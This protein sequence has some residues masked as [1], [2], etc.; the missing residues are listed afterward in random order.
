M[1][2]QSERGHIVHRFPQSG[3]ISDFCK[4]LQGLGWDGIYLSAAGGGGG[5]GTGY[6]APWAQQMFDA[7]ATLRPE[8]RLAAANIHFFL[9]DTHSTE[10]KVMLKP[11]A[12]STDQST[13]GRQHI[14]WPTRCLQDIKMS[15]STAD[16][17]TAKR[18]R[19][20]ERQ[21]RGRPPLPPP[22]PMMP[23]AEAVAAAVAKPSG[24]GKFANLEDYPPGYHFVCAADIV[25]LLR[26]QREHARQCTGNPVLRASGVTKKGFEATYHF[27]CDKCPAFTWRAA[28][29]ANSLY[30][31]ARALT[32]VQQRPL[33]N[34]L[35]TM[36][37]DPPPR[38]TCTADNTYAAAM[39][40]VAA[41]GEQEI[42]AALQEAVDRG[43]IVI[44]FDATH[45][46]QRA[47]DKTVCTGIDIVS[48]KVVYME[49]ITHDKS[50]MREQIGLQNM[51]DKMHSMEGLCVMAVATD[52]CGKSSKTVHTRARSGTE[53]HSAILSLIDIWHKVKNVRKAMALKSKL[54]SSLE[55]AAVAV[56]RHAE[57]CCGEHGVPLTHALMRGCV[58]AAARAAGGRWRAG[59]VREQAAADATTP[60]LSAQYLR[61]TVSASDVAGVLDPPRDAPT[62][63]ALGTVHAAIRDLRAAKAAPASA[64]EKLAAT[65]AKLAGAASKKRAAAATSRAAATAKGEKAKTPK[66]KAAAAAAAGA[67]E[68]KEAAA[69]VAEAKAASA[70][71]AADTASAAPDAASAAAGN[72]S[73][74]TSGSSSS[75]DSDGG[76]GGGLPSLASWRA[77]KAPQAE[78]KAAIKAL[79]GAEPPH[80][81][82]VQRADE[83]R[84][85]LDE[86]WP[87]CA[88]YTPGSSV[89][90]MLALAKAAVGEHVQQQA[91]AGGGAAAAAA[92]Q[93]E[94]GSVVVAALNKTLEEGSQVKHPKGAV[95]FESVQDVKDRAKLTR[96]KRYVT[97]EQL[98]AAIRALGHD[99]SNLSGS[100]HGSLS[101]FLQSKLSGTVADEWASAAKPAAA[102][103]S[104]QKGSLSRAIV[105]LSRDTNL[106]FPR[107]SRRWKG[108][109]VCEG[110][111]AAGPGHLSGD[112]SKCGSYASYTKCANVQCAHGST[113]WQ[114]KLEVWADDGPQCELS[115]FCYEL[116]VRS[117]TVTGCVL[118]VVLSPV[119]T[120]WVE[121]FFHC[122]HLRSSKA[123]HLGVEL[124]GARAYATVLDWHEQRAAK[125]L[126]LGTLCS[127]KTHPAGIWRSQQ[128]L[129]HHQLRQWQ[130]RTI[131]R[132][133]HEWAQASEDPLAPLFEL[134][135]RACGAADD[136]RRAAARAKREAFVAESDAETRARAEAGELELPDPR[137]GV[138]MSDAGELVAEVVERSAERRQAP[139]P[140]KALRRAD[141]VAEQ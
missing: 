5:Y 82:G 121:S 56:V 112:H 92:A 80:A 128:D 119:Q 125:V 126:T 141:R 18:R 60:L 130:M 64:A 26:E 1:R 10:T 52:P 44:A 88:A 100:D 41:L 129:G 55:S 96:G 8:K 49:V 14:P 13:K 54:I 136:Q 35:R 36:L 135:A 27:R 85:A 23:L 110:L 103:V 12:V 86:I 117:T 30:G 53:L 38:S 69:V 34:A 45:E 113:K 75:S 43:W 16:A 15:P 89:A 6:P 65:A 61:G 120:S 4:W 42:A 9:E 47:S 51:L 19:P 21:E 127:V 99:P 122:L 102:A 115:R 20:P 133:A 90:D 76:S 116:L 81:V 17:S 68:K 59:F 108:W 24:K 37:L 77:H 138:E 94:V 78:L 62:Q 58:A 83:L 32:G 114:P 139:A 106:D 2:N 95:P 111:A 39:A 98:A 63:A 109:R 134:H 140:L 40:A 91:A 67:A 74:N 101:S 79:G 22:P 97:P 11:C 25:R 137:Q 72:C 71:E 28:P 50:E 123:T 7:Q 31:A 107:C 73:S 57:E 29:G 87:G 84:L 70:E 104:A 33:Q 131:E 48:G 124:Y 132:L 3:T 105:R 46:T 93:G 118:S 66:Q